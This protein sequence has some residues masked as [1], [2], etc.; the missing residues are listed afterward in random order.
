MDNNAKEFLEMVLV[1]ILIPALPLLGRYIQ[2]W[3]KARI[4]ALQRHME[5]E[6]ENYYLRQLEDFVMTSVLAVQQTYVEAL[7]QENAFTKEAQ[8]EAVLKAK[9][10]VQTQLT[11]RGREVLRKAQG[12]YLTY[13]EDQIEKLVLLD[14]R[15]QE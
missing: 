14:H 2:L 6:E 8:K 7:K 15:A 13:I 9:A 12:D 11:S 4:E 3:F 5:L 1:A 10:K